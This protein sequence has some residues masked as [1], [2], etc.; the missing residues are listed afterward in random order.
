MTIGIIGAM[1]EELSALLPALTNRTQTEI[2]SRCY[3]CGQIEGKDVAIALSRIGKVAAASSVTTLIDRFAPSSIVFTGVAGSASPEVKIGDVVVASSLIQHDMDAS[4]IMGFK[5]F[6]IP[7]LGRSLFETDSTLRERALK[8]ASDFI[9]TDPKHKGSLVHQ[10]IIASGDQFMVDTEK[11]KALVQAI[12]G[13][14][15]VEMEGAAVAQVCYEWKMP[16]I[17]L[18]SISDNADHQAHIDFPKFIKEIAA[19]LSAGVVHRLLKQL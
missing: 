1:E 19:P 10:G 8:A 11:T 9:S 15:A 12:P 16:F 4:A 18:R 2:G 7:L 6:E 17:V 14:L 5:R 3:Y 13:L